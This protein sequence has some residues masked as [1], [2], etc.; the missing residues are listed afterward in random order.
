MLESPT[1]PA[2][3]RRLVT[4]FVR[5]CDDAGVCP[6]WTLDTV[7]DGG[8]DHNWGSAEL[9]ADIARALAGNSDNDDAWDA[10]RSLVWDELGWCPTCGG[11]QC[12]CG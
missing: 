10:V 5:M 9:V 7:Q 1:I 8:P 2:E 3:H 4:I 6:S 11:E 12:V